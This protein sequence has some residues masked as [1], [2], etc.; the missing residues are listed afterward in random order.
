[1]NAMTTPLAWC[2]C[3][4]ALLFAMP[5][6]TWARAEKE[7][8]SA[9]KPK[10]MDP[11]EFLK[12]LEGTWEGTVKT[13]FEPGKLAD[14]SRIKGSFVRVMDG[15]FLRHEYTGSMQNKP[16][17]GEELIAFNAVARRFESSWIDDFHMNYAILFSTGESTATGFSVQGKYDAAPNAPKWGWKT[18]FERIDAN[19][20]T[21]T[22]YNITPE[23]QE[24]KAVETVYTRTQP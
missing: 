19:H 16:R 22:A 5:P 4:L 13:W 15:R 24:A 6:A 1:M 20:L 12:F 7:P 18:V 8:T 9:T 2:L 17:R 21:I 14:E 10:T 11:K 3:A 23:G